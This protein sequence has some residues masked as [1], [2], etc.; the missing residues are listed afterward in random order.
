MARIPRE[1]I[2]Q[3]RQEADI[4]AVI[5]DYVP[6]TKRGVN[7]MCSCPFHEDRSPSF[8]VSPEKQIYK[9]SSCGRAGNVFGFIQEM[10]GIDFVEAV[11]KVAELSNLTLDANYFAADDSQVKRPQQRLIEIHQKAQEFYSFYLL[12]TVAGEVALNYLL[13][14]QLAEATIRQFQIGLAPENSQLLVQY[15][16]EASFTTEE[17]LASGI[18]YEAGSELQDR[19][20]G[21]I[22]FPLSNRNGQVVAFS[23]RL[24][25]NSTGE[26]DV[27]KY[28]NSPET[29]IFHK[30]QLV[31]HLAPARP[32]I[33][34]LNQVLICEGYMDVIAL[35]QAGYEHTVATM[36]TSLTAD[37]LKQLAKWADELLFVFDGD[38]AGKKATARAFELSLSLVGKTIKA[39]QIPNKQDPDEWIKARG[40]AS[41]QTLINQAVPRFEFLKDYLKQDYNLV[42]VQQ[43]AEYISKVMQLVVAL[44][45]TLEQQMR[46]QALAQ[47]FGIAEAVLQEQLAQ[48]AYQVQQQVE[49]QT[50]QIQRATQ[51]IQHVERIEVEPIKSAKAYHCERYILSNLIYYEAAWQ[52]MEQLEEPLYFVHQT[53]QLIYFQLQQYY[54]DRGQAMPLT[55]IINAGQSASEQQY[56]ATLMWEHVPTEYSQTA[57]MD[58]IQAIREAFV[59]IEL[60]ELQQKLQAAQLTGDKAQINLYLVDI[61]R[62]NRQLK[63][64][65]G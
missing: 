40:A 55:D 4:V 30:S 41:F 28:V 37:H 61:L 56:L 57:M 21:R 9:C 6:L 51:Q 1:V 54:Y 53:A 58:C 16:Q 25:Q 63:N 65:G 47:E 17:M 7:Y 26:R 49:H 35:V 62:L 33:R 60:K 44:P 48:T 50:Q 23:G 14:R 34:R 22:I 32:A 13:E 45:S 11:R 29:P 15:L 39:I 5:Q 10:E 24:Y 8:S 3:I 59:V 2:D 42:D 64:Q 19:F 38:S 27:A 52:L 12:E 31:Y 36:G 20:R 46:L 18:F 43:R